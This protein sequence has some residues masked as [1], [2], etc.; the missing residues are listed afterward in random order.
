[1]KDCNRSIT[2]TQGSAATVG[3]GSLPAR[4]KIRNLAA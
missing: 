3:N 4:G 1:M 2:A